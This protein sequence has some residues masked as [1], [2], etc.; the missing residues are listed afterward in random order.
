MIGR[1]ELPYPS[2]N[3][4]FNVLSIG[5]Q[6]TLSFLFLGRDYNLRFKLV[7]GNW[8]VITEQERKMEYSWA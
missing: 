2:M 6:Y 8:V 5:L 4:I 7:G 1:R 3:N